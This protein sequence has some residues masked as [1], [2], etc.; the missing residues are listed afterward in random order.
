M[1]IDSLQEFKTTFAD[2]PKVSD[3][4]W[5]GN[6]ANWVDER[7]TNKMDLPGLGGPPR[8][9]TFNKLVFQA[10]IL[11]MLPT[12]DQAAAILQLANAWA[13]A[14]G[15]MV[16][17]PLTYIEPQA[18]ATTWAVVDSSVF[19]AVSIEAG[20]QKILELQNAEPVADVL[21]SPFPIKFNE[22]FLLLTVTTSGQDSTPSP[23]GPLPLVDAARA[24]E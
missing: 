11:T 19:D 12:N 16:V 20:R 24:V 6:L 21:E 17:A 1:A 5:A 8:V 13:S 15:Q 18:P 22:A 23:A 10:S 9:Y 7:V 2:L 14:V 4:S 3:P